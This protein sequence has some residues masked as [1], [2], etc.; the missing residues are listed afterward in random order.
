ML[1][2]SI[3]IV[4]Y[5]SADHGDFR[6]ITKTWVEEYFSLEPFDIAQ[7]EDPEGT[8]LNQGG[9]ILMAKAGG[10][11]LGT[12]GLK[13]VAEGVYEMIKLGVASSHQGKGV[14]RLLSIAIMDQARFMGGRKL[15]LYSN[16]KLKAALKLYRSLG[17]VETSLECGKYLRCDIK[18]E[19]DL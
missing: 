2:E 1:T 8:V 15:I 14:G 7:L 17:F 19:I 10:V 4:P 5:T 3:V 11:T 13:Y 12:V 16:T 9:A 6:D 18:M